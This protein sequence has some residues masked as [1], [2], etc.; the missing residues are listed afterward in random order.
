MVAVLL[1]GGCYHP[2]PPAGAP[3]NSR[4]EC[5]S[6]LECVDD[7]CQEPGTLPVDAAIDACPETVCLGDDLAGCG[8][9]ITCALG[10]AEGGGAKLPHCLEMIPSNGVTTEMLVGATADLLGLDYDFNTDTGEVTKDAGNV[11]VRGAGPGVIDGIG[12]TVVDKMAVFS[13][14]SAI[15]A[16]LVDDADDWD[17]DGANAF[18][19]YAATTIDVIGRIDVGANGTDAGPAGSNGGMTN[20]IVGCR[21]RA[22]LW[23]ATGFGEGGGGGGART[24]GGN[25]APSNLA[26]F[27]A[28]GPSCSGQ[29]TTIPLRGGYGGGVGGYDPTGMT[30]H[31]G[32]GGGGGGAMA[33]VAMESIT[34]SGQVA[35]P[36]SGGKSPAAADG[37]GGGGAGG[38]V[39]LESPVVTITGA[40]TAN[41][42]GGGAPSADDGSRGHTTDGSSA[43]GGAFNTGNG[44]RG[45]TGNVTPGNGTNF[46]DLV[47][48]RGGGGGGAAGRTEI[49]SRSR[50]T[51]GAILSPGPALTDIATQ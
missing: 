20:A 4:G 11:K 47:T 28:G 49:K 29:P 25:G 21:G 16:K 44:G 19:L 27:G 13:V 14:H 12:F 3:C 41:G 43:G 36:G 5:P 1:T 39:L 48:S 23:Q 9:R 32:I 6:G 51:T 26:T 46:T 17:A 40:L 31:G 2:T 50:T 38:A 30:A 42:G 7:L 15:V 35:S 37:G 33:L 45:G 8:S 10:C 18:V 22:G 34:I 24:A